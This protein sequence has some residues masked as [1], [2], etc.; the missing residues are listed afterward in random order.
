MMAK[1]KAPE[2][3]IQ[4]RKEPYKNHSEKNEPYKMLERTT[5]P[6]RRRVLIEEGLAESSEK[7]HS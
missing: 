1:V 2:W 4:I 6:P 7:Q 5:K 3:S